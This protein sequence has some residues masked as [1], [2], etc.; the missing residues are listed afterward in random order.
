MD[1]SL[2]PEFLASTTGEVLYSQRYCLLKLGEHHIA[3]DMTDLFVNITH[4]IL[5]I[6]G[7]YKR[8]PTFKRQYA[9]RSSRTGNYTGT[10]VSFE[11]AY[12]FCDKQ[13]HREIRKV[14]EDTQRDLIRRRER[15]VALFYLLLLKG[16]Q[17]GLHSMNDQP[18]Q[19]GTSVCRA[20]QCGR[21]MFLAAL[22]LAS[23]DLQDR[24]HSTRA[25]SKICGLRV[26][27]INENEK[28]YLKYIDY[29][30]HIKKDVFENWSR[31]V[32][33]L[34][35]LSKLNAM[36]SEAEQTPPP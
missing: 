21:R 22:M 34:S 23:K 28:A 4:L 17:A 29:N 25:W 20:I 26:R 6:D 7:N 30:L 15:E 32:L 11:S 16:K 19:L 36:V 10:Y 9:F 13:G 3:I 8:L 24:N 14:L 12:N 1:N 2:P 33:T 18:E 27:E 5:A 35:K 31:I